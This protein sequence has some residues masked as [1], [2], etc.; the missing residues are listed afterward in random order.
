MN[1]V[2]LQTCDQSGSVAVKKPTVHVLGGRELSG[3]SHSAAPARGHTAGL[4]RVTAHTSLVPTQL[5]ASVTGEEL[6]GSDFH[7]RNPF[8]HLLLLDTL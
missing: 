5:P 6:R 2:Q 3:R 8:S 1:S 7:E 4:P